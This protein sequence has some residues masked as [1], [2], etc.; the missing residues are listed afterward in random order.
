[1]QA[2]D[3]VIEARWMVPVRP[4]STVHEHHAVAIDQ[5]RIVA[6]APIAQLRARYRPAARVALE[7]HVLMPGLVNAHAHSAMSLLRGIGED[8]PLER[9]LQQRIWP[10]ERAI[11]SAEFVYD[12]TRLAAA[13]MLRAGI[14]C[15][16]DM[17][18]FPAEAAQAMRS[19]GMRAVVGVLIIDFPSRYASD[20][21]DHLRRGLA[22]R[23]ALAADPLIH[24]TLAPHAPYTVADQTLARVATL[25][26]EL[27]LPVH[28]HVHETAREIEQSR[29]THGVRPLERLDRLGLVSERLLAV[30]ATQLLDAEI[31]LLARRGASVAHCPSS[32]CKLASGIA[33]VTR[34]LAAGVRVGIGT[35]GATSNNRIDLLGEASLAALLAKAHAA[36]ATAMPCWQALECATLG[37]AQCLGLDS[38]IGSLE[39]GKEADLAALDLSS[40]ETQPCYDVIAQIVHSAG[41]ENVTHAWVGGRPVLAGRV[42][43]RVPSSGSG[44]ALEDEVLLAAAPWHN[45]IRQ[46]LHG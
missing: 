4:R 39:E 33:P 16:N 37:G 23:D 45:L 46:K 25:A 24:F 2:V 10:L 36:D 44:T 28:M 9:W 14:T 38:R 3:T 41:R 17:Y 11:V 34:L 20:A 40:I 1:M 31:D 13:E 21:D 26:E 32:N 22:A 15:C 35:D 18:F 43:T 7:H 29:N 8:L 30:H 12:G 6:L 42:L 27:D 19:L 5:G